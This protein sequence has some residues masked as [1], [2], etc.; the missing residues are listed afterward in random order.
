MGCFEKLAYVGLTCILTYQVWYNLTGAME[1]GGKYMDTKELLYSVGSL[2]PAI[3]LGIHACKLAFAKSDEARM[4]LA[5]SKLSK[6]I[7]YFYMTLFAG[8]LVFRV[9]IRV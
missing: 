8:M 1:L 2:V 5:A 7:C 6:L 4:A 9:F 3:I